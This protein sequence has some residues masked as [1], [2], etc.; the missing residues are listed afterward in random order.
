LARWITHRTTTQIAKSNMCCVDALAEAGRRQ[1]NCGG[2][3]EPTAGYLF[4]NAWLLASALVQVEDDLPDFIFVQDVV[5]YGHGRVPRCR[6]VWKSRATFGNT[7]EQERLRQLRDRSR[8]LEVGRWRVEALGKMSV[9]IERITMAE[10][11][12]FIV[13]DAPLL[14]ILSQMRLIGTQRIDRHLFQIQPPALEVHRR[15]RGRMHH[16]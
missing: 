6:G 16:P 5:R 9:A 7:P 14:N 2:V 10:K 11:A 8:V 15:G 12:I 4:H 13:D 1:M 3:L